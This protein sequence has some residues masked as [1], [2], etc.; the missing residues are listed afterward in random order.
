MVAKIVQGVDLRGMVEARQE[1]RRKQQGD[2]EK[3]RC[4]ERDGGTPPGKKSRDEARAFPFA[5]ARE[6][7][8]GEAEWKF[9]AF[10]AR[11]DANE[12]GEA[13]FLIVN[14][15]AGRANF[16]MREQ[17]GIGARFEGAMLEI[18]DFFAS[19]VTIGSHTFEY[20]STRRR[21]WLRARCKRDRTV[22]IEQPMISEIS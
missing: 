19:G 2:H 18:N 14:C 7:C 3:G 1:H 15:S 17:N 12:F 8:G 20:F 11:M 9:E 4:G 5:R 13:R 21:S 22:P 10:G 16:D 6:R